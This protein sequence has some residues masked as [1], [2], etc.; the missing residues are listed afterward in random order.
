MKLLVSDWLILCFLAQLFAISQI[1]V[2]ITWRKK[3][4]S[5]SKHRIK[6]APTGQDELREK[7]EKIKFKFLLQTV[8]P[9]IAE[10]R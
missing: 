5:M 7:E 9:L 1:E 6:K 10:G 4:Y 3:I 2:E 8:I